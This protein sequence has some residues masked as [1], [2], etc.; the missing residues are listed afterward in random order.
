MFIN[1]AH[2]LKWDLS[3]PQVMGILNATPDSFFAQSRVQKE[4]VILEKVA[5]YINEGAQVIDIG[6][7]STRPGAIRIDIPTEI[8]RLLPVIEIIKHHYPHQLISID[9]YQSVVAEAALKAGAHIINDISAGSFDS[10]ILKVVGQYHAGYIGMHITGTPDTMHEIVNRTQLMPTLLSYF[11]AKKVQFKKL[12]IENWVIDPG[13]GFG[14]TMLE[15]FEMVKKLELLKALDLPILL[16]V[17]RKSTI[18]KTLGISAE[19]ALNGT[20][21]L[22]TLGLLNGASILR[23]HDVKQAVELIKLLPYLQ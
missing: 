4:A 13:F 12:G 16:G 20:T 11:E 6:G 3:S 8:S 23:V 14:K 10:A 1:A 15:N 9:T 2:H 17:S 18:Y 7:Q 5:Q 21:V 19:E 22:N